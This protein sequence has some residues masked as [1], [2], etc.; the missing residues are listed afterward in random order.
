MSERPFQ[1]DF[2]HEPDLPQRLREDLAAVSGGRLK[3][4]EAVDRAVL[5]EAERR[6]AALRP[7]EQPSRWRIGPWIGGLSAAAAVLLTAGMV[8]LFS[9]DGPGNLQMTHS[10]VA[11]QPVDPADLDR[12]GAVDI[13]DAFT[14]A[15]DLETGQTLPD[16]WD[17]NADGQVDRRDADDLAMRV[18]RLN[19]GAG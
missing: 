5:A 10:E 1:A 2:A 4:P 17:F 14:L 13:L 12:S 16:A 15:R 19:G 9:G 11:T 18:V 8:I 3:V 6:L 7:V